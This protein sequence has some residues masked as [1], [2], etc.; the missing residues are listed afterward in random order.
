M[1]GVRRIYAASS[2][3]KPK[4][5]FNDSFTLGFGFLTTWKAM[6]QSTAMFKRYGLRRLSNAYLWMIWAEI[7]VCLAFSIACWLYIRGIITPR[8]VDKLAIVIRHLTDS[9]KVSLSTLAS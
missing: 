2:G 1:L 4:S 7:A 8:Y 5:D 6:K 9:L 3:K